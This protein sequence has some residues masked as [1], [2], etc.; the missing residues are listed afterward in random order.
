[1]DKIIIKDLELYCHHGVYQEETVLGQKFLVSA[2]LYTDTEKA[3]SS[4][5][6]EYSVN[7]AEVCHFIEKYM[8]NHTY[9][10]IEAAAGHLAAALLAEFKLVN[11]L[12]LEL[13]K[14]WAPILL[15]LDTVSVEI[16]RGWHTVYLGIGSNMGDKEQNLLSAIRMLKEDKQIRRVRSSSFHI[17]EPVGEVE[18]DDFL[19]GAV[20]IE[21]LK[22]PE[23]LLDLI[24]RIEQALKRV[25][26]VH[27]G[28]RTIDV[29]IL[30]YED[31]VLQTERLTI[32]HIQMHKRA[33]VLD[34]LSEI[35]PYARHPVMGM[36]VQQ[37][38][39]QLN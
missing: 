25:R 29:D 5:D 19:N 22:S 20:E 2:V 30:L 24:S 9:K 39:E 34:P 4:D 12:C 37:L 33:F 26:T 1:M 32:P 31:M 16:E 7:Y 10:L 27:W 3:G 23:E 11:K 15:P 17:T 18:Q 21:T 28:P 35:A 8:K 13:K 14:P 36:T 6:L 38:R